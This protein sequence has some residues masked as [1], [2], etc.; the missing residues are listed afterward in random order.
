MIRLRKSAGFSSFISRFIVPVIIV[1]LECYA[2]WG[3]SYEFCYLQ[4]Y[5]RFDQKSVCIGLIVISVVLILLLWFVWFQV[6]IVGPGKQPTIPPFRILPEN[7]LSEPENE[8]PMR[9]IIPPDIYPC[10]EQGY[11]I[12][13]S[14]CQSLKMARTHHSNKLGYCIPRFD[15]YCIWIGTV[16]GR[17][18]YKLFIQLTLSYLLIS[19]I[20][21]ISV[22]VYI[23]KMKST[24]NGNVYAIFGLACCAVPVSYTHLD[25]YKR[26]AL[27]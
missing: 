18:N 16:I 15:H 4:L 20:V 24:V 17:K 11:P 3:Y 21:L 26:Q 2:V 12:W 5:Q 27:C 13:C 19:F 8:G 25:V 9:S 10:D 14:N 1:L 6:L 7:S 22:A 23:P